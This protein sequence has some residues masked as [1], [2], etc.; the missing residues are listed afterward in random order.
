MNTTKANINHFQNK[1]KTHAC[2]PGLR[3][4]VIKQQTCKN[5][6]KSDE[7]SV[8]EAEKKGKEVDVS[9]GVKRGKLR[10]YNHAQSHH[11]YEMV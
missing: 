5:R 1:S 4:Y 10:N 7:E 8:G 6:G 2:I 9:K 3:G 11:C